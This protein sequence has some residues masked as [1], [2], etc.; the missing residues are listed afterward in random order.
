M[1]I[2]KQKIIF[3][4]AIILIIIASG[5]YYWSANSSSLPTGFAQSNYRGAGLQIVWP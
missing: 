4:V 2:N 5:F 1:K 3:Y